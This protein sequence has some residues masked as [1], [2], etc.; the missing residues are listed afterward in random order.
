MASL[1]IPP[2]TRGGSGQSDVISPSVTIPSGMTSIGITYSIPQTDRNNA[3]NS[4]WQRIEIVDGRRGDLA[5]LD[6]RRRVDGR[7]RLGE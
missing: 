5:A 1:T 3:A 6:G 2:A 4:I 7:I